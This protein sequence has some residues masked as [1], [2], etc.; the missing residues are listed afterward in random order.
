[1]TRQNR[2]SVFSL[3]LP[4]LDFDEQVGL[5]HDTGWDGI[6]IRVADLEPGK[7]NEPYSF[8][9]NRRDGIGPSNIPGLVPSI[10]AACNKADIQVSALAPYAMSTEPKAFELSARAAAA[11]DCGLVRVMAPWYVD[12]AKFEKLFS[13][14]RT[15]LKKIEPVARRYKVKAA[16]EIHMNG[17]ASSPS[18]ARRLVEGFDPACIGITLDPGNMVYEGFEQWRMACEILGPYLA[19]VHMKNAVWKKQA[20]NPPKPAVWKCEGAPLREGYANW[21]EVMAALR[22]VKYR[23]WLSLEDFTPGPHREKLSSILAFLK[24]L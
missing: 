24:S 4:D 9:G 5:L 3:I 12:D 22:A 14:A 1:M 23:G 16:L 10:K 15:G 18:G 6:E 8:W 11:L 21:A 13:A 19:H 20:D 7:K 2:F 17:I